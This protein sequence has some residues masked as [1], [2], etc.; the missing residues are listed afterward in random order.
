MNNMIDSIIEFL[1][2]QVGRLLLEFTLDIGNSRSWGLS[3]VRQIA[4][5]FNCIELINLFLSFLVLIN[6]LRRR[7]LRFASHS[8]DHSISI[9]IDS[10]KLTNVAF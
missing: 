5:Y 7:D 2:F 8:L 3:L 1:F 10:L 9:F 6:L 4:C